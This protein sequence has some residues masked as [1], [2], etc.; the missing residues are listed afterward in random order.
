MGKKNTV[1]TILLLAIGFIVGTI[2]IFK[3]LSA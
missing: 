1:F 2:K 3:N